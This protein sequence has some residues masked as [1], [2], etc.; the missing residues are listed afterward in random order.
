MIHLIVWTFLKVLLTAVILMMPL[1]FFVFYC[2][3]S[4]RLDR[5]V[6]AVVPFIL[7]TCLTTLL[8][9]LLYAIWTVVP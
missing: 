1:T 2:I 3:D 8:I 7:G 6:G 4:P 9:V 5:I